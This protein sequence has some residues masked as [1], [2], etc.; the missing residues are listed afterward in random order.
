MLESYYLL[1][2]RA[3]FLLKL[4]YVFVSLLHLV[5]AVLDLLLHFFGL[6]P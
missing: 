2:V 1:L 3:L 5:F 6:G 4:L